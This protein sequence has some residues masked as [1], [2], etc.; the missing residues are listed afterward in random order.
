MRAGL[1]LVYLAVLAVMVGVTTWA[2]LE[3]SVLEAGD[4]FADRWFVATLIDAYAGFL[5][6]CIWIAFRERGVSRVVWIVLILTLGNIT[7]ALYMLIALFRLDRGD[8]W[9]QLLLGPARQEAE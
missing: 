5:T 8:S 4:L 7:F 9:R 2:S 1:I 3:R 6:F